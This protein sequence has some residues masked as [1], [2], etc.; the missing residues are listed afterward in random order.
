MVT[1]R[2]V[3]MWT[4]ER[5]HIT[6]SHEVCRADTPCSL[7][8]KKTLLHSIKSRSWIL[9]CLK[10]PILDRKSYGSRDRGSGCKRGL[11]IFIFVFLLEAY[12]IST[13][14]QRD[15]GWWLSTCFLETLVLHWKRGSYISLLGFCNHGSIGCRWRHVREMSFSCSGALNEPC[16]VEYR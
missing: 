9:R 10:T 4:G 1:L 8:G 2:G 14:L 7:S 11:Q 3:W 5:R 13:L 16:G 15:P 12:I 6:M